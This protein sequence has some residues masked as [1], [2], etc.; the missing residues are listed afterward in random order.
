MSVRPAL[1][2][3]S[4]V[5]TYINV[6]YWLVYFNTRAVFGVSVPMA[7]KQIDSLLFEFHY[8]GAL[9]ALSESFQLYGVGYTF[10]EPSYITLT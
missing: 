9:L 3:Q 1:L 2:H 7:L 8:T 4:G 5:F 10:L 6:P